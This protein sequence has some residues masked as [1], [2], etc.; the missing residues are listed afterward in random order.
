MKYEEFL[1]GYVPELQ[2]LDALDAL[3]DYSLDAAAILDRMVSHSNSE[4]S[5]AS[6]DQMDPK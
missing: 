4:K 5:D 2:L 1:A 6:P 3:K